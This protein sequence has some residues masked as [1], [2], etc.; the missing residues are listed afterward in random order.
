M[1]DSSWT[2]VA[3][4]SGRARG[5]TQSQYTTP[6]VHSNY[7]DPLAQWTPSPLS[8][9]SSFEDVTIGEEIHNRFALSI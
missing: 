6:P 5:A 9:A 7:Y 4:R 2:E 1:E 3:L 8:S